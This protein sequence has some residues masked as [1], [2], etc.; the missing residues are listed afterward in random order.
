MS[1]PAL[2]VSGERGSGGGWKAE[3]REGLGADDGW[4]IRFLLFNSQTFMCSWGFLKSYRA[5]HVQGCT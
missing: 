4:A 1:D 3:R 2:R 5:F